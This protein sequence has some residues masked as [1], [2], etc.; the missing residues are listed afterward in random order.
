MSACFSC[1]SLSESG[2]KYHIYYGAESFK[3]C[4]PGTYEE[5]NKKGIS[6]RL[7]ARTRMHSQLLRAR[8]IPLAI[9]SCARADN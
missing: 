9:T 7:I 1:H 2:K 6:N 5:Y 8:E 4:A 3:P